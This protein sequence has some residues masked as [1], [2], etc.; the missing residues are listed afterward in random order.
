MCTNNWVDC[1]TKQISSRS[2]V[3]CINAYATVESKQNTVSLPAFNEHIQPGWRK[4]SMV[5]QLINRLNMWLQSVLFSTFI[6]NHPFQLNL[7]TGGWKKI[8]I[9]FALEIGVSSTKIPCNLTSCVIVIYIC[10]H[11]HVNHA[12]FMAHVCVWWHEKDKLLILTI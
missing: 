2:V 3:I 11:F 6:K 12:P 8:R 1:S 10:I 7:R 5:I 9:F 4:F